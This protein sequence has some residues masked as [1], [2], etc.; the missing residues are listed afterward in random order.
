MAANFTRSTDGGRT[1][2]DKTA[3]GNEE[4]QRGKD[5]GAEK[6]K[7]I[8]HDHTMSDAFPLYT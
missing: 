7:A 1:D 2:G 4:T 8:L 6:L 5:K 3:G